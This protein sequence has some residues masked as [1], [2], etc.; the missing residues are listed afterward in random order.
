MECGRITGIFGTNSSGKSSILQFLLMLKQTRESTDRYAILELNG[1][2]V[3]LG[4]YEDLMRQGQPKTISFDLRIRN[5]F[6]TNLNRIN[7]STSYE[8]FGVAIN[9]DFNNSK[10]PQI[11]LSYESEGGT[12]S[13]DP[14]QPGVLVFLEKDSDRSYRDSNLEENHKVKS[15]MFPVPIDLIYHS[16]EPAV[17]VDLFYRFQRDAF[18]VHWVFE[19]FCD[20]TYYLGPLRMVPRRNYIWASSR[21][22]DVGSRGERCIDAILAATSLEE[23]EKTDKFELPFQARVARSLEQLGLVSG[24]RMVKISDKS[25]IWHALIRVQPNSPEVPLTDVGFGISQ[26]LPVVTLLHYV[27]EKS[28]VLLE[29]PELHLHPLA[30]ANLADF[31]IDVARERN[32]QIIV[33]SHS[34]QFLLRLQRRVAEETIPADEIRLYFVDMID[35]RSQLVKLDLDE[36]GSIRNWPKDFMGDA[37]GETAKAELA[38]VKR[39]KRARGE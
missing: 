25:S 27:P 13:Y 3:E 19:N 31:I 17:I 37:F 35:G 15:Y 18:A 14:N 32:L 8:E 1:N 28:V 11:S 7:E 16:D 23:I 9:I 38:R 6:K 30:Q 22:R 26:V 33:E 20:Q 29:Q 10:R 36:F 34:E 39:R 24:F 12:L 2:Y 21:P 4:T 5:E